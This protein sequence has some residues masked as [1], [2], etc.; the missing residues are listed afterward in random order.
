MITELMTAETCSKEEHKGVKAS[1]YCSMCEEFFCS[2]CAAVHHDL[3]PRHAKYEQKRDEKKSGPIFTGKCPVPSHYRS[4]LVYF[5]HSHNVLCC[6]ECKNPGEA[7]CDCKVDQIRNLD[8]DALK[9][10]FLADL[11]ALSAEI[12]SID[13]KK[14]AIFTNIAELQKKREEFEKSIGEIRAAIDASFNRLRKAITDRETALLTQLEEVQEKESDAID[15]LALSTENLRIEAEQALEA[16]NQAA[17]NWDNERLGEMVKAVSDVR[18]EISKIRGITSGAEASIAPPPKVAYKDTLEEIVPKI[19]NFGYISVGRSGGK[20]V[21]EWR[22]APLCS[23]LPDDATAVVAVGGNRTPDITKD[24]LP[25]KAVTRWRIKFLKNG[26][27]WWLW[28]GVAPE[29][30]DLSKTSNETSCGWYLNTYNS[31]LYSGPPHNYSS[32]DYAKGKLR[33][34]GIGSILDVSMNTSDG[35]LSF[36]GD[37]G[38]TFVPAYSNIPLNQPL[39]P[40]VIFNHKGHSVQILPSND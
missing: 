1:M 36:S 29:S 9:K 39:Y 38:R 18:R 11:K 27:G 32:K 10:A 17:E 34:F 40:A 30:I 2:A 26:D 20:Y 4:P 35:T 16:G 25:S 24:P 6:A 13:G 12:Q 7:H 28:V 23:P 21:S 37:G 33:D 5:C 22:E 19:D 14:D 15:M 31:T 3:L 8:I